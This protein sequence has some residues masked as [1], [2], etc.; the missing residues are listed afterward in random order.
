MLV[1]YEPAIMDR[2]RE[3]HAEAMAEKRA[4]HKVVLSPLEMN[5]LRAWLIDTGWFPPT[6]TAMPDTILGM[7]LEM[8]QAE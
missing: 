1:V 3:V 8:E 6:P 4:V 5:E 7:R 2:L